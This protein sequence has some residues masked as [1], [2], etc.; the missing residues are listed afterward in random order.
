LMH[1][2]K[3]IDG[4][5]L[6]CT[7]QKQTPSHFAIDCRISQ[8]FWKE[9]YTFFQTEAEEKHPQSMEEILKASNIKDP[10]KRKSALWLHITIIYEIWLWYTQ[11]RWGNNTIPEE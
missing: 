7:N 8:I 9:G 5:C 4:N 6:N 2:N 11:A 1:I 10:E 3:E